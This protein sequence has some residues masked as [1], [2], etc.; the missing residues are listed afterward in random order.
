M[1]FDLTISEFTRDMFLGKDLLVF[2]A[3]TWRPYCHIRDFAEL[4]RRTLEAPVD[5][6]AFDV[7]NAGGEQNNFT[8]QMIVD[9]ILK[10]LPEAQVRYQEHGADPRNYRVDFS[11]IQERLLFEPAYAVKD[12]IR[13]L[14]AALQQGLFR[15]ISQPTSFHGNWEINYPG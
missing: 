3:D 1:R 13:E 11:K 10:Q 5:N 14:I 15:D 7:F 4:I 8:K 2:D 12:G 9:A 6:V